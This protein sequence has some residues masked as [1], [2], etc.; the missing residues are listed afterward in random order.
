VDA[1]ACKVAECETCRPHGMVEWGAVSAWRMR[2]A[3]DEG[4]GGVKQD[5]PR[6]GWSPFNWWREMRRPP[7]RQPRRERV[8]MALRRFAHRRG[9]LWSPSQAWR[10]VPFG[11]HGV[12][13]LPVNKRHAADVLRAHQR[14]DAAMQR[15]MGD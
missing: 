4:I 7:W 12:R 3:D 15:W 14:H 6:G 5:C 8:V 1:V 10:G 9:W 13:L 11:R 2:E